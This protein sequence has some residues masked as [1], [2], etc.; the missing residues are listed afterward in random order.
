MMDPEKGRF[1]PVSAEKVSEMQ[2]ELD[3]LAAQATPD[4]PVR[5][6]VLPVLAENEEIN[7]EVGGYLGQVPVTIRKIKPNGK[8]FVWTPH[9][10]ALSC[11]PVG[12]V[13]EIKGVKFRLARTNVK[14]DA[15]L[16]MMTSVEVA[17]WEQAGKPQPLLLVR[18]SDEV[19]IT[20]VP[21]PGIV[22]PELKV[23][24][25]L[26]NPSN[27]AYPVSTDAQL[28]R[29]EQKERRLQALSERREKNRERAERDRAT[30]P[31]YAQST[32]ESKA[33]QQR[34][35]QQAIEARRKR[36]AAAR[37]ARKPQKPVDAAT[38]R[39]TQRMVHMPEPSKVVDRLLATVGSEKGSA[40]ALLSLILIGGFLLWFG[41]TWVAKASQTA[42]VWVGTQQVFEGSAACVGVASA[43]AST[44]V[45]IG[46]PC[47]FPSVHYT[48][49]DVKVVVK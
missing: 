33:E 14:G 42:T 2:K 11:V 23:E 47:K 36:K 40:D 19:T 31:V 8:L 39:K 7:L 18:L 4:R 37:D 25:V 46:F 22:T 17:L 44:S 6:R 35:T 24:C 5:T 21:N 49:H 26:E 12:F 41:I 1:R 38:L 10:E 13:I 30:L 29:A 15:G 16:R 27:R 48:D 9:V 32:P 3:T 20:E 45:D 43:G 28:R 34:Y